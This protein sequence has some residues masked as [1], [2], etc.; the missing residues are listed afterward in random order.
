MIENIKFSYLGTATH[1][2][3]YYNTSHT[4]NDPHLEH[5]KPDCKCHCLHHLIIGNVRCKY[6]GPTTAH[7]PRG[8]VGK[9]F[10]G[11]GGG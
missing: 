11:E 10:F 5:T 2:I 4:I 9:C 3:S 1:H 8:F 6:N 7:H